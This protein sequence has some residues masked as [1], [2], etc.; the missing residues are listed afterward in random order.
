[1]PKRP[2]LCSRIEQPSF[3][4]LEMMSSPIPTPLSATVILTISSLCLF[5]SF[6]VFFSKSILISLAPA[7]T[8][9]STISPSPFSTE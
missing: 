2:F 9:L 4:H 5:P 1:M 7:S 3:K 6:T 8:A